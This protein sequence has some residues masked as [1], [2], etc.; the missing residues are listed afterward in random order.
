MIQNA[1][2]YPPIQK[3]SYHQAPVV[4]MSDSATHSDKKTVDKA[5]CS[6]NNFPQDGNLSSGKRYTKF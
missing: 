2:C 1:T 4:E 5:I 6:S 3:L